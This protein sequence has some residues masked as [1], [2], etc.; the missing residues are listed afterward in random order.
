MALAFVT[1][2]CDARRNARIAAAHAAHVVVVWRVEGGWSDPF[3]IFEEAGPKKI[4]V[5]SVGFN[6]RGARKGE[7]F[8]LEKF[9]DT[10]QKSL[11]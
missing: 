3:A 10:T 5:L 6:W 4:K 7:L 2:L 11:T 8:E 9:F 1:V